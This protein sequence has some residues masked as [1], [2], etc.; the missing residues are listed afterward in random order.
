[1]PYSIETKDGITIANIPDDIA[2]DSDILRQRVAAERAKRNEED[3]TTGGA[4]AADDITP[5]DADSGE[6]E[7]SRSMGRARTKRSPTPLTVR[8][9][10]LNKLEELRGRNP[11]LASVIDDMGTAERLLV[12]TGKGLSDIAQAAGLGGKLGIHE[13]TQDEERLFKELKDVSGAAVA[14]EIAGQ[15]LPFIPAGIGAGGVASLP[16]RAATTAAI[17]GLEGAAI[18]A[19]Q[20]KETADILVGAT[21]GTLIG[22]GAELALPIVNRLGRKLINKITGKTADA[23]T[24]E[25]AITKEFAE[26]L[27]QSNTSIDDLMEAVDLERAAD[28]V[29]Y[30]ADDV[31]AN[32]GREKAFKE[33]GLDVTE[34]ERTR[35]TDLFVKQQDAFRMSG[36]VKDLVEKREFQLNE[37]IGTAQQNARAGATSADTPIN[38]VVNKSLFLDDEIG[39]LYKIARD[40]AG[41]GKNIQFNQTAEKL[42]RLAP[43]NTRS[44]G[45]VQALRDEMVEMGVLNKNFKPTGKISV[46]Q[47]EELRIISNSLFDGANP[48]A[49][50]VIREFKDAL[51]D[52][53]FRA[54]GDDVFKSARKAKT[55][56]ERGLTKNKL[57]K[58]DTNKVSLVR[59]M[60]NNKVAPED[61][62]DRAVKA[63]SRY[64]AAD[65][66]ELKNYLHEGT[67]EQIQAGIAAWNNVRG[68]ALRHIADTA[69]TGAETRLGTRSLSR[70]KYSQALK[71][72]GSEKLNVLFSPNERGLLNKIAAVAA[73]KEPPPGTFTGSGPSS[74]AI[75]LAEQTLSLKLG[76]IYGAI[77]DALIKPIKENATE[78]QVLNIIDDL[79]KIEADNTRKMFEVLRKSRAI[80]GAVS[81]G[82]AGAIAATASSE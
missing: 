65:L 56:F 24:P 32:L 10:R 13:N 35:N 5:Q 12:G 29:P 30:A 4:V 33:L 38:A 2:S 75:K 59:D 17:G 51:D 21:L 31:A 42:R 16:A 8:Q 81:A 46:Q 74:P 26:A 15:A 44:E 67:P 49:K 50:G 43:R 3:D 53:V 23:L 52:D 25:G 9:D 82:T 1:M 19:G 41:E 78:K 62:F 80:E 70:A 11:Y 77:S 79:A 28:E 14:G 66:V 57:H 54:T 63:K 73:L 20:A 22:G 37:L 36:R 68:D 7:R 18:P 47:A 45:T 58:F 61:F 27:D 40:R 71:S 34:A 6:Q 72:I 48:V 55:N 69:F 60:L 64:K 76:I 39:D